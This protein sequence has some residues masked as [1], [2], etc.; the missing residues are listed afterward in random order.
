MALQPMDLDRWR[1]L[2][3]RL[4]ERI[5]QHTLTVIAAGVAFY[6]FLALVPTLI[7]MVSIFG[8]LA[9]PAEVEIQVEEFGRALPEEARKLVVA[10]LE[11]VARSSGSSVTVTT[12]FSTLIALWSASTGV[13]NLMRGVS[14]ASGTAD[15]RN[16]AVKRGIALVFMLTGALFVTIATIVVALLPSLLADTGLTDEVRLVIQALRFP[17]LAA[18]SIVGLG[19]IYHYSEPVSPGRP[20]LL[21]WGTVT[22]T[23]VWLVS[24]AGF[25]FYTANYGRYNEIYGSL[26]AVVVLLLWL[27]LSA[28][29][30]LVGAEIDAAI[31]AGP[32]LAGPDDDQE[33]A[34]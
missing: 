8:L 28:L 15:I 32:D 18:L 29:A 13:M 17:L 7:V 22:A 16:L 25:S 23:A 21:S 11:D 24:S 20:R 3:A 30:V 26:G 10:Q 31:D 19:L 1:R 4:R 33:A 2:P 14:V 9:E 6:A 27:W 34:A 12:V 5:P